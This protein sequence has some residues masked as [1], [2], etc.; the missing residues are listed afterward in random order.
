MI[1]LFIEYLE[2]WIDYW[3]ECAEEGLNSYFKKPKLI[4]N[5]NSMKNYFFLI[6]F[7]MLLL[8]CQEKDRYA[9]ARKIFNQTIEIHDQVMPMMPEL[10]IIRNSLKA[11]RDS[12]NNKEIQMKSLLKIKELK[13]RTEE[14]L[15]KGKKLLSSI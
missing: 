6:M 2:Y 5:Y 9:E 13:N 12:I 7:L 4:V 8:N 1:K 15:T 3:N 10:R 11:K 14:S